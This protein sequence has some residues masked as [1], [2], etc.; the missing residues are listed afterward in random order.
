MAA[1]TL[2]ELLISLAILTAVI[3]AVAPA[4]RELI[5]ANEMSSAVSRLMRSINLARQEAI[6]RNQTVSICPVASLEASPS[7]CSG[8]YSIGWMVFSNDNR[9][10]KVDPGT[11][12][13][14]RVIAGPGLDFV[15]TNRD[16][17][18]IVSDSIHYDANGTSGRNRTLQFCSNNQIAVRSVSIVL[19]IVGRPRQARNWGVCPS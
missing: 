18:R 14:L 6:S 15:V 7:S 10:R 4:Y 2:V 16:G 9:N 11:D 17:S 13:V 12:E 1:F 8:T 19:N 3:S 5:A